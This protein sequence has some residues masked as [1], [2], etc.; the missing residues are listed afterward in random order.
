[1]SKDKSI[2]DRKQTQP[3]LTTKENSKSTK[4]FQKEMEE[5]RNLAEVHKRIRLEKQNTGRVMSVSEAQELI[6]EENK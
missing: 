2:F 4:N 3:P 5:R 6:D 1:M